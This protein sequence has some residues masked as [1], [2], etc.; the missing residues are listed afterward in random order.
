MRNRFEKT[1]FHKIVRFLQAVA[2]DSDLV[3]TGN[4]TVGG[5]VTLSEPINGV[6]VYR[7][8]L[9]WDASSNE[10]T[11]KVLENSLGIVVVAKLNNFWLKIT[12]TGA[13]IAGK[14][15]DNIGALE[16]P[17]IFED[18]AEYHSMKLIRINDNELNLSWFRYEYSQN[19]SFVF[20]TA[21]VDY[22]IEIIV[23]P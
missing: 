23:Y 18:N 7:A 12:S 11:I 15:W 10:P 19:D 5:D 14:W 17:F 3:I 8:L 6:K 2:F 16:K 9:S 21:L 13:F 20:T 4:L 22:P 1:K